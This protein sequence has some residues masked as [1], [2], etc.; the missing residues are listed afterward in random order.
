M[1]ARGPRRLPE[2]CHVFRFHNIDYANYGSGF[3]H[4]AQATLSL[5]TRR[6]PA[7]LGPAANVPTTRYA[8]SQADP[9]D[10]LAPHTNGT[11]RDGQRR[12]M[13]AEWWKCPTPATCVRTAVRFVRSPARPP[14]LAV[15]T[16][17]ASLAPY[18]KPCFSWSGLFL[19]KT[20][21]IE[22]AKSVA[23]LLH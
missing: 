11:P 12:P 6:N 2:G 23:L 1:E 17:C 8:A 18:L 22:V 9:P 15:R 13:G 14:K 5:H 20:R 21:R 16:L 19:F 10:A 4:A 3:S 7:S